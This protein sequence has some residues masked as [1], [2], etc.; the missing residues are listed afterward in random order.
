MDSLR[1]PPP[2][3]IALEDAT[4]PPL[5]G[6][7]IRLREARPGDLPALRVF[8]SGEAVRFT[9]PPPASDDEFRAF[10]ASLPKRRA[11]GRLI[12]LVLTL[13][14]SDEAVGI[15]QLWPVEGNI[16]NWGFALSREH[17]GQRLFSRS[18][19]LLLPFA[20][21]LGASALDGWCCVANTRGNRA[22]ASLAGI[23][24]LVWNGTDP[25]GLHDDFIVWRVRLRGDASLWRQ[26]SS[27]ATAS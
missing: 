1:Q 24:R 17:W 10:L 8:L 18:A 21:S 12:C 26:P 13:P 16:W 27:A 23:P 9:A 15:F 3:G 14:P 5:E 19:A 7:G 20:E 25:G 11:L 4:L 2:A 6:D 22:L